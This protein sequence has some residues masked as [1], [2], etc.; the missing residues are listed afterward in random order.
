LT[1]KSLKPTDII[2]NNGKIESIKGLEFYEGG[3]TSTIKDRVSGKQETK[4]TLLKKSVYS[5][6]KAYTQ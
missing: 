2:L 5:L 1:F 4:L 3:Y 6:W